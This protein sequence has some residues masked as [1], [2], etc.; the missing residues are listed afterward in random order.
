VKIATEVE[1]RLSSIDEPLT[2]AVMGCMVN[3]PGEAKEADI[4]LACGKGVGILFKRGELYRRFRE[5]TIIPEFVREVKR[6]AQE[7]QKNESSR[8][9]DEKSRKR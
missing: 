6:L 2:V 9:L 4:G 7:R 1:R 8:G 3:G 5:K